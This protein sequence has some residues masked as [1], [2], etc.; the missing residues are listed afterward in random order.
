M[1]REIEVTGTDIVMVAVFVATEMALVWRWL[2][3]Q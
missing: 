3:R 1:R 2:W